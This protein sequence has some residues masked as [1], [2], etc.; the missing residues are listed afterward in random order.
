MPDWIVEQ[1][2]L[3]AFF[4]DGQTDAPGTSWFALATGEDPDQVQ[5][6]KGGPSLEIGTY[7]GMQLVAERA[8]SRLDIRF[9]QSEDTLVDNWAA[10]TSWDGIGPCLDV[11]RQ[12]AGRLEGPLRIAFGAVGVVRSLDIPDAYRTLTEQVKAPPLDDQLWELIVHISRRRPWEGQSLNCIARWMLLHRARITLVRGAAAGV[13][14]VQEDSLGV[15][16]EV[17]ISTPALMPEAIGRPAETF[18]ELVRIGIELMEKG[19]QHA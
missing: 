12:A 15:R 11:L 14:T 5:K 19:D 3:T 16:C 18:D 7:R 4:P 8:A 2:R 1:L 13:S 6:H 17:D 10:V 9:E